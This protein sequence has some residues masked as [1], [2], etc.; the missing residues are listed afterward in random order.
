MKKWLEVVLCP[1]CHN[2]NSSD[3][4]RIKI[5]YYKFGRKNIELP[6]SGVAIV[7]CQECGLFYKKTV[8][9]K[10]FLSDVFASETE[11]VWNDRHDYKDEVTLLKDITKGVPFDIID[12]GSST[13]ALLD[14]VQVLTKRRSALDV[15][16]YGGTAEFVNGEYIFGFIDSPSLKW[17]NTPYDVVTAYDVFEHLYDASKSFENISALLKEGGHLVIETG[18]TECVAVKKFGIAS[19]WYTNLFEHHIFWNVRAFEYAAH[20][21]GFEI[22]LYKDKKHKQLICN[23]G[24]PNYF[25]QRLFNLSPKLYRTVFD[26]MGKHNI[27]PRDFKS[28]DHVLFV[29]R[30]GR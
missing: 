15:M 5:N 13:G 24:W 14:V 30:K 18:N 3:C 9:S 16:R 22:T 11:E 1:L 17:S 27:Q 8:P 20:R 10:E 4:G 21:Y 25:K 29:M 19:W 23:P 28:D 7:Q 6:E 12:I 2:E 26:I